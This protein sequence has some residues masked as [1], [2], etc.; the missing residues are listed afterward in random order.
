MRP[1]QRARRMVGYLPPV[2]QTG[3][4]L[5]LFFETLGQELGQMELWLT[6]LM[7]SRWYTLARGFRPD[8]SLSVK[9]ASELGRLGALYGLVPRRGESDTYFRQRI[10]ALVELHRTGLST[11]PSLLGLVSLVYMAQQPPE[12]SWEGEIAIGT[13]QVPEADGST[14][15]MRVTLADKPLTPASTRFLGIGAG[16][17]L[18]TTNNGLEEAIPEIC[19]KAAEAD[20][21]IP[22]LHHE[23]SGLD[24]IFL[25]LVP[26]GQ[27]LT[28]RDKYVPL[29]DGRPVKEPVIVAHPTRF[30]GREDQGPR[31]RFN[32]PDSRFAVFK[33]DNELPP[34]V[35]GRNH[36]SY[37][38][39]TRAK[40]TSYLRGTPGLEL[41]KALA[42]IPEGKPSPRADLQFNWIE[43][44]PAT[45]T[46]SIPVDY[47]PPHLQVPGEDGTVPGL[48]GLVRELAAAL[49]YGRA[50]G[51]RWRIELILP[52][53]AEEVSLGESPAL[54]E[55]ATS[56]TEEAR[57]TDSPIA[58]APN[59]ILTEQVGEL[60][61]SRLTWSGFFDHTR[62]NTSRFKP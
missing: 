60:D 11:A 6:R 57:A 55:L 43:L 23:E 10:A 52:M 7:R 32:A 26:K 46:L 12:L 13:F 33:Q 1:E 47:V 49:T 17:Q 54:M 22:L 3:R 27:T 56:F 9:A 16:Q 28:L 53:P 51:V 39:L 36:W 38:T 59:L 62:F 19:L 41:D 31:A 45:F 44:A 4:Q 15:E 21:P 34:L 5:N 35:P 50:A 37:E 8:D 58:V 29:L 42:L 18:L 20:I 61:D 24:V 2:L 40:L 48:P 30:S 14:R 25:G